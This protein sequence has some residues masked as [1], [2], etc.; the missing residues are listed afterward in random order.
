MMLVYVLLC[1]YDKCI[2][3][4]ANGRNIIYSGFPTISCTILHYTVYKAALVDTTVY[5]G[6]Q[7]SLTHYDNMYPISIH[8]YMYV[9]C[10]VCSAIF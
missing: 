8:S 9:S 5:T 2:M 4:C 6:L 7:H 1:C 10:C 3:S